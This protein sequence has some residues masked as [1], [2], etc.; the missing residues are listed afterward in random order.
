M[1]DLSSYGYCEIEEENGHNTIPAR[2]TAV[3]RDRYELICEEGPV[4]AQLKTAVYY[5]RESEPFPTA[6]DF[7]RI[8]YNESGDSLIVKT[9]PRRSLFSR[10]DPTPGQ[11]EQ[12]VAANFDYVFILSSLNHDFKVGR[13]ERYLTLAWQSGGTPVVVLTKRDKAENLEET[14]CKAREAAPGVDVFAISSVTGEGLDALAPYLKPRKTLVFLGSSGVGKSSLVNALAGKTVMDT[15]A[16]REK[17]SRGRH[18][19]THRQLLMLKS[20]VMVIDT[21]GMREIGMWDAEDGLSGAFSDVEDFLGRCKFSDCTHKNEPGCAIRAAISDGSLSEKRWQ[22]YLSL[23][24]ENRYV[25]DKMGYLR[26]KQQW[27]KEISKW[28][29]EKKKAGGKFR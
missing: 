19:T 10:L 23:Q 22:S 11:G 20:G 25:E 13:L 12:A 4:F 7:V 26:E 27:H 9:L 16:I 21:P 3:H 1:I 8:Q 24:A 6:G 29:K 14:V 28:T 18:T 5:G 2:V 15:G 17:N